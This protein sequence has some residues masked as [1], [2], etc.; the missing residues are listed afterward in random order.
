MVYTINKKEYILINVMFISDKKYK[1]T[2]ETLITKHE[3][4]IQDIIPISRISLFTFLGL[5][6]PKIKLAILVPTQYIS[7]FNKE[8]YDSI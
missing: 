6:S 2:L 8:L 7:Y 1:K 3:C 5:Y 4:L